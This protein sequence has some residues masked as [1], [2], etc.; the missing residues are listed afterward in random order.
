MLG[1]IGLFNWNHFRLCKSRYSARSK[2]R[3]RRTLGGGSS[4]MNKEEENED[5]D[6]EEEEDEENED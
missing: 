3:G 1:D 5:E 2:E 6:E 4:V